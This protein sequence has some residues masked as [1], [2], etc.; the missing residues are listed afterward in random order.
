M[1]DKIKA[2]IAR[3]DKIRREILTK[4][5]ELNVY[6]LKVHFYGRLEDYFR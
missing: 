6:R 4:Y 2:E 1:I 5:P 3:Y